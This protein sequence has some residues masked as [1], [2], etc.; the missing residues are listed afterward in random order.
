MIDFSNIIQI[1]F[2]YYN[3]HSNTV[4]IFN[5]A[6]MTRLVR[7]VSYYPTGEPLRSGVG[8]LEG[9]F[10][11]VLLV[12]GGDLLRL[13]P[14]EDDLEH[15]LEREFLLLLSLLELRFDF[16]TGEGE[17]EPDLERLSERGERDIDFDLD[18]PEPR[19]EPLPE[20]DEVER[21]CERDLDIDLLL[22]SD[23][24]RLERSWWPPLLRFGVGDLE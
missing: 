2:Q 7:R 13:L 6:A 1:L 14:L 12:S 15:D 17:R 20:R 22:E 4:G 24:A 10:E 18:R 5:F 3:S 16:P 21:V 19:D 9:V 8:V 23:L 11:G